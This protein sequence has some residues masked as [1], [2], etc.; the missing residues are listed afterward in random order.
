MYELNFLIF[1]VHHWGMLE[2]LVVIEIFWQIMCLIMKLEVVICEVQCYINVYYYFYCWV[3]YNSF[4]SQWPMYEC[5][6]VP[7]KA[8]LFFQRK[9]KGSHYITVFSD[10][11][12][13][14]EIIN[15]AGE[16]QMLQHHQG[17]LTLTNVSY[18]MRR[19][20]CSEIGL[21]QNGQ[22]HKEDVQSLKRHILRYATYK[23]KNILTVVKS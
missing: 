16:L 22:E 17:H 8:D 4:V 15:C 2:D 18:P 3:I 5:F 21:L 1:F 10:K 20:L 9:K 13:Y 11:K 6:C 23:Q 19:V 12:H 7:V 14:H